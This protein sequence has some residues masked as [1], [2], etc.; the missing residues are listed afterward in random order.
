MIVSLTASKVSL[1]SGG[2][3]GNLNSS[4]QAAIVNA[5]FDSPTVN[6][7]TCPSNSSC[8][9]ATAA[10]LGVCSSC[11]NVTAETEKYCPKVQSY[12]PK[13][14]DYTTPSNFT[15]QSIS[16]SAS[17]DSNYMTRINTTARTTTTTD[18]GGIMSFATLLL[19]P[20][21]SMDVHECSLSWC[22]KTF[23][24]VTAQGSSFSV[25][26]DYYPLNAKSNWIGPF[27]N[28][29]VIY[30]APSGFPTS[31]NSTF[32]V[33]VTNAM[34]L[35]NF[36]VSVLNTGSLIEYA[37]GQSGFSSTFTLGPAIM[38]NP[39]TPYMADSI[40]TSLTNTLRN[41][42]TDYIT[43]NLGDSAVQIQYI[44]VR[45]EWLAL[46]ASIVLLGILLLLTTMIESHR[47]KALV[48]KCSSLA[49]L[50]HPLQG[51]DT[52]DITHTSKKEMDKCAKEM[53]G[54][55]SQSDDAVLRIIK[56]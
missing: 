21:G 30:E 18:K 48:W 41:L 19:D 54:Q 14:C 17:A 39:S 6:V 36:L 43:H 22:A 12:S 4:V 24:D 47:N 20:S 11:T 45:W 34:A 16:F 5:I 2:S 23:S 7:W 35:S 46:P 56:A 32:T 52:G 28:P 8:V 25:H 38:N 3:D 37:F 50:F 10:T 40:A 44:R 49:L 13:V 42:T 9:W 55:L 53:R 51:W 33:Q 1:R 29:F 31:L 15:L 26:V 27:G